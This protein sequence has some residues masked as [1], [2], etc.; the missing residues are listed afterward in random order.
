L[1]NVGNYSIH[2]Q[3]G[4]KRD[5]F[6]QPQV[7]VDALLLRKTC[8]RVEARYIGK[9]KINFEGKIVPSMFLMV[10]LAFCEITL[11]SDVHSHLCR[12]MVVTCEEET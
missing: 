4:L 9:T 12:A 11:L 7:E 10:A 8:I 5:G 1:H 6:S 2:Q 3:S